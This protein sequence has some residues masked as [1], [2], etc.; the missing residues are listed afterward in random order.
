M[1]Y[2]SLLNQAKAQKSTRSN[3]VTL[4]QD[5]STARLDWQTMSADS[6]NLCPNSLLIV[7]GASIVKRNRA[8]FQLAKSRLD[9]FNHGVP[10]DYKSAQEE[11]AV[12][13]RSILELTLQASVVCLDRD[14]AERTISF[15]RK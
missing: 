2:L 11:N 12:E 10:F 14:L 4:M 5:D 13:V 6:I 3:S 7:L 15:G 9:C 8:L 1:G